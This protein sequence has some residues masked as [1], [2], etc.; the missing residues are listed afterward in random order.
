MTYSILLDIRQKPDFYVLSF[1][2]TL[3]EC[4]SMQDDPGASWSLPKSDWTSEFVEPKSLKG[5]NQHPYPG[6]IAKLELA[7][8]SGGV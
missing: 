6:R 2:G 5:P 4:E 8:S 1:A 3:A 7:A